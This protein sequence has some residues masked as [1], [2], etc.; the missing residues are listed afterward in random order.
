[1]CV[2]AARVLIVSTHTGY[3]KRAGN[4]C[5]GGVEAALVER[6]KVPCPLSA[7]AIAAIALCVAFVMLVSAA[8]AWFVLHRRWQHKQQPADVSA[9]AVE[10]PQVAGSAPVAVA[11][12]EQ[13]AEDF[14]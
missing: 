9:A 1:M 6:V 14:L 8:V 10:L 12:E 3:R 4:T 5:T 7:G 13:I 11:D 2:C